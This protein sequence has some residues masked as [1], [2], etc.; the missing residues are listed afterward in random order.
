[1][2]TKA[3]GKTT[4]HT[5]AASKIKKGSKVMQRFLDPNVK[6]VTRPPP[7]MGP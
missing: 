7:T 1:M 6:P 3:L 2:E 4:P 5:K